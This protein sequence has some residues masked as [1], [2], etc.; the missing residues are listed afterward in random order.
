MCNN[1]KNAF[2]SLWKKY[3]KRY[4]EILCL[5]KFKTGDK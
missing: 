2:N 1:H 4:I 5:F 3:L